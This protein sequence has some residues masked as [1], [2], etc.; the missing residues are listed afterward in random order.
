MKTHEIMRPEAECV[1]PNDTLAAAAQVMR[2]NEVPA[3][4]VL[5]HQQPTGV[6][7]DRRIDLHSYAVGKH[8]AQIRVRDAVDE[9]QIHVKENDEA[10]FAV[11]L[12]KANGVQKLPVMT[13]D[14]KVAGVIF[15][16]DALAKTEADK[17]S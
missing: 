2:R 1:G 8:P 16:E 13:E 17:T 6:L 12:M 11:E 15:L 5:D 3:V 4:P 7:T 9:K 14:G 10:I